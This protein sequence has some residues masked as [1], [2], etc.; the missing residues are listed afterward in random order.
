[1]TIHIF[2]NCPLLSWLYERSIHNSEQ[3]DHSFKSGRNR[4]LAGNVGIRLVNV[5]TSGTV[6]GPGE[7]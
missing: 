6:A 4:Q 3:P 2:W 7:Y 1:M 5:M